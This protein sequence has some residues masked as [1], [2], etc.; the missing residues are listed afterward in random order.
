MIVAQS[1]APSTWR[2]IITISIACIA[3]KHGCREI[4]AARITT[5]LVARAQGDSLN[6]ISGKHAPCRHASNP[7]TPRCAC[8]VDSRKYVRERTAPRR[9]CSRHPKMPPQQWY[10]KSLLHAHSRD[11]AKR[12]ARIVTSFLIFF[13]PKKQ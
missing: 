8:L 6:A 7:Y 3:K 2:I 13:V 9:M 11:S 5:T 1:K 12:S 10:A 4:A